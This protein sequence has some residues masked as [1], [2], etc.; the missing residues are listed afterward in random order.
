VVSREEMLAS[1]RARY[2]AIEPADGMGGLGGRGSAPA[3]RFRLQDGT[4]FGIVASTT[5]PFCRSCD[6]SRLTADGHWYLCLYARVGVDLRHA[7]RSGE[8][9]REIGAR[10]ARAWTGRA[11]RGAEERAI[12]H[13]REPLAKVGALREDPH[14]E[15]H[16]R[17][18]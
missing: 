10:I 5:A 1:L 12:L 15:M 9:P 11:D 16:T 14:L 3:E 18:G 8:S 17:G 7:L 13:Q 4:V 2:G 6:R